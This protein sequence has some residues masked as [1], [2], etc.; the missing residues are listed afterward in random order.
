MYVFYYHEM[1]INFKKWN[2]KPT[3]LINIFVF[4]NFFKGM[5]IYLLLFYLK[6]CNGN[7][8]NWEMRIKKP[9]RSR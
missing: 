8:K 3:N 4:S 1:K 5:T 2:L 7:W 6:I 9:K